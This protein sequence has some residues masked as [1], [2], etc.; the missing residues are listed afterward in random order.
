MD[1]RLGKR[2]SLT[3]R[4]HG[5]GTKNQEKGDR[6]VLDEI[7]GCILRYLW[8]LIPPLAGF[9]SCRGSQISGRCRNRASPL[10]ILYAFHGM[11]NHA[12]NIG[13]IFFIGRVA[14]PE[15]EQNF[16]SLSCN[17]DRADI[18]RFRVFCQGNPFHRSP[19]KG[20]PRV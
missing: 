16:V 6:A 2:P 13:L 4:S 10:F 9:E 18:V 8:L 5:S 12:N 1:P 3:L 19:L 15:P 17:T 7:H 11:K 20:I 14:A